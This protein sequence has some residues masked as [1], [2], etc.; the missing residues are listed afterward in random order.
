LK[1]KAF[2]ESG[3]EGR[4]MKVVGKIVVSFFL[5]L[6][7]TFITVIQRKPPLNGDVRIQKQDGREQGPGCA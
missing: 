7:K 1:L 6:E 2:P 4:N 3:C 5:R